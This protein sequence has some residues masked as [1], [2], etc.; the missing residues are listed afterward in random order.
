MF[1]LYPVIVTPNRRHCGQWRG[2]IK[3]KSRDGLGSRCLRSALAEEKSRHAASGVVTR[4][5]CAGYTAMDI[6]Q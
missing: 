2:E 3:G 5:T 6:R 4:P 1:S